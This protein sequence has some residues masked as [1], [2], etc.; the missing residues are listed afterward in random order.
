MPR[1]ATND[2]NTPEHRLLMAVLLNGMLH[3]QRGGDDPSARE[4]ARWI[5]G[6]FD[7]DPPCPFTA[8]CDALDIDAS[9]LAQR[10]LS[11]SAPVSLAVKIPRRQVRRDFLRRKRGPYRPRRQILG[12]HGK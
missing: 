1:A 9:Y 5:R 6:E 12:S 4:A 2:Y 7:D 10:L 8:V 11:A 3:L